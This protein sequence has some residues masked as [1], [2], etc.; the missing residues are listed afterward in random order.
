MYLISG[1][2]PAPYHPEFPDPGLSVLLQRP[3]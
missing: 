2:A 3:A 1:G